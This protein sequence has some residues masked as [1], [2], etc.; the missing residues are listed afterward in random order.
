MPVKRLNPSFSRRHC[1]SVNI[2]ARRNPK[3]APK[4]PKV[5]ICPGEAE[6]QPP[7]SKTPSYVRA[8]IQRSKRNRK[9]IGYPRHVLYGQGACRSMCNEENPRLLRC[10]LDNKVSGY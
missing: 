4:K 10:V 1:L 6:C 5:A 7:D 9:S 8:G 3:I 2:V